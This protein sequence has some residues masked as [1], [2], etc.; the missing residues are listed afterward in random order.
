MSTIDLFACSLGAFVLLTLILLPYYL[1]IDRS[2]LDVIEE[3]QSN[4]AERDQQLEESDRNLVQCNAN[5]TEMTEARDNIEQ[6]MQAATAQASALES[7]LSAAQA[8]SVQAREQLYAC[9][10]IEK[11]SFM[12]VL[13]S[14]E[15]ADDVDLH[16][17]DPAGRRYYFRER[18]LAGSVAAFEEDNTRGPGNEVW[19]HPGA[20]PGGPCFTKEVNLKYQK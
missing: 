13:M 9:S 7:R 20:E 4:L 6:Q 11:I 12:L 18:E 19:L 10:D 1:N 2:Y 15:S 3:L 16:V 8:E 17:V 14:W 5:L